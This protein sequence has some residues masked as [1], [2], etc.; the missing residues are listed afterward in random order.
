MVRCYCFVCAILDTPSGS[1]PAAAGI[2]FRPLN[3]TPAGAPDCA[4]HSHQKSLNLFGAS[5][6]YTAVLVIDPGPSH[7]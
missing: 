7:P 3:G 2:Q 4:S 1:K 6:V 5:A